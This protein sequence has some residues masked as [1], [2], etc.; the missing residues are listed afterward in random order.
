[1]NC[2][3]WYKYQ[4]RSVGAA[5]LLGKQQHEREKD[6]R[7]TGKYRHFDRLGEKHVAEGHR[8]RQAD[9]VDRDEERGSARL[10]ALV[11]AS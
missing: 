2:G 3:D 11:T 4:V 8:Q 10:I 6:D 7:P 5:P 1:M 9:E